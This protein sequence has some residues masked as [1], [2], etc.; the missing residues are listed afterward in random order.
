MAAP[1]PAPRAAHKDFVLTAPSPP[2]SHARCFHLGLSPPPQAS[3]QQPPT[4][5][6]LRLVPALFPT[7][8]S[9]CDNT[10]SAETSGHIPHPTDK[11]QSPRSALPP[12]HTDTPL[13]FRPQDPGPG[14]PPSVPSFILTSPRPQDPSEHRK[15]PSQIPWLLV[16]CCLSSESTFYHLMAA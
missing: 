14:P 9:Q 10:A 3:P 11:L 2:P 12:A 13:G 16:L 6:Q 5:S 1:P 15:K 7:T 4:Q 8:H